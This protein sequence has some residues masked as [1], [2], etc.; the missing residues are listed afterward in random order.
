MKYVL[1]MVTQNKSTIVVVA[2]ASGDTDYTNE[3]RIELQNV[4]GN[5][6]LKYF[7]TC[8]DTRSLHILLTYSCSYS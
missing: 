4:S 5:F 6:F 2:V 1:L 7:K 8:A 3:S